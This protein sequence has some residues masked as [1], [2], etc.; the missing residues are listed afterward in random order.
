MAFKQKNNIKFYYD[1]LDLKRTLKKHIENINYA[2]EAGLKVDYTIN[3]YLE[4]SD[5]LLSGL[6]KIKNEK[7]YY[8]DNYLKKSSQQLISIPNS[9]NEF[10]V[11]SSQYRSKKADHEMAGW[12][13]YVGTHPSYYPNNYRQRENVP[14]GFFTD[15]RE[16]EVIGRNNFMIAD[17]YESKID[18]LF[19]YDIVG[20]HRKEISSIDISSLYGHEDWEGGGHIDTHGLI[21]SNMKYYK[22]NPDNSWNVYTV[23]PQPVRDESNEDWEY[24]GQSKY[25][26]IINYW[27]YDKTT[28]KI[29]T[30][31]GGGDGESLRRR[32]MKPYCMLLNLIEK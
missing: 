27:H 1:Y 6:N 29:N 16:I 10:V 11:F 7:Y 23:K 8:N 3:E 30:K 18:K 5:E 25:S 2:R 15:S 21:Y 14:P 32:E 26:N 19:Q 20:V 28:T 9:T 22:K 4:S 12:G 24:I 13:D 31:F 17:V